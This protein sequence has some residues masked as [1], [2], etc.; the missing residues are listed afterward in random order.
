[1]KINLHSKFKRHNK[2]ETEHEIINKVVNE[3]KMTESI[4]KHQFQVCDNTRLNKN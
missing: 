3:T 2:I 4:S 1:M